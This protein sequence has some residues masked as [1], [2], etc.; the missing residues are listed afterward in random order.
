M[1]DNLLLNFHIL[2]ADSRPRKYPCPRK[3]RRR[4][5]SRWV[6]W[7][8]SYCSCSP[9]SLTLWK[10][11]RCVVLFIFNWPTYWAKK[12]PHGMERKK[13]CSNTCHTIVDVALQLF[14]GFPCFSRAVILFAILFCSVFCMLWYLS[15]TNYGQTIQLLIGGFPELLNLKTVKYRFNHAQNKQTKG[16]DIKNMFIYIYQ[17]PLKTL[18]IILSR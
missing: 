8:I 9:L 16:R 4:S 18:P 2:S 6:F 10:M 15:C 14:F 1:C 17:S 7:G 13:G 11:W 12:G 3:R 5:S